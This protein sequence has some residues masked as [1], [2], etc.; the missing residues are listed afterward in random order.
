MLVLVV[1][2]VMVLVLVLV[3]MLVF[4]GLAFGMAAY[5]IG[6]CLARVC[7]SVIALE[8]RVSTGSDKLLACAHICPSTW[9]TWRLAR[10][11]TLHV[12]IRLSSRA[13]V[14]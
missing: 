12:S 14:G 6:A 2:V 7:L 3:S 1:V 11:L 13:R 9:R 5:I 8:S 10:L 4:V